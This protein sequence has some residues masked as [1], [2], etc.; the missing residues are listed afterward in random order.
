MNKIPSR[1]E[2]SIGLISQ[3]GKLRQ[4]GVAPCVYGLAKSAKC[5]P[6]TPRG[7]GPGS[8]AALPSSPGVGRAWAHPLSLMDPGSPARSRVRGR[9][10][11]AE[12][13]LARPCC[14]LP[15]LG[16]FSLLFIETLRGREGFAHAAS[17]MSLS[18]SSFSG[19]VLCRNSR[20]LLSHEQVQFMSVVIRSCAGGRRAAVPF[21]WCAWPRREHGCAPVSFGPCVRLSGVQAW[22]PTPLAHGLCL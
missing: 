5:Q 13:P 16:Y 21:G 10:L 12:P 11:W 18:P 4:G 9:W 19:P 20:I 7:A 15:A 1:A 6:W 2:N 14:A 3:V 17:T 8:W 22:V